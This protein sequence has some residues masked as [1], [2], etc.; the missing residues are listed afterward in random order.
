M[1]G[2]QAILF[3]VNLLGFGPSMAVP[4]AV[5]LSVR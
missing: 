3:V 2:V 5:G 4:S 1:L